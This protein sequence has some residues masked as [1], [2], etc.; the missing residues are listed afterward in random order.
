MILNVSI[1]PVHVLVKWKHVSILPVRVH[2]KTPKKAV[3][4]TYFT[5]F[6]PV[7]INIERKAY[8]RL[9]FKTGHKSFLH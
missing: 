9:H 6:L 1:L 4:K 2:S 3:S 7:K 5:R 8:E